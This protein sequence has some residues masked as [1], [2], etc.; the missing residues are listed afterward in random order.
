MHIWYKYGHVSLLWT[1]Q[2]EVCFYHLIL[3]QHVYNNTILLWQVVFFIVSDIR[4]TKL[5]CQVMLTKHIMFLQAA[6]LTLF[7]L[8]FFF[9]TFSMLFSCKSTSLNILYSSFVSCWCALFLIMSVHMKKRSDIEFI[10]E[11][12]RKRSLLL[13]T[14]KD[15]NCCVGWNN[16][17]KVRTRT[18]LVRKMLYKFTKCLLQL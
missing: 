16:N 14:C 4:H 13:K 3:S 6:A 7:L 12:R 9:I 1:K 18:M 17:S 11:W 5:Y 15:C 10:M 8:K 2:T